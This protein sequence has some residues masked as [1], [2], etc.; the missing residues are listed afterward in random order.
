MKLRGIKAEN[1]KCHT[2]VDF[3][4]KK[5]DTVKWKL[6]HM[7]HRKQKNGFDFAETA[8]YHMETETEKSKD[9]QKTEVCF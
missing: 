5:F 6:S 7:K 2:E 9:S 4:M 1:T 3:F 8:K